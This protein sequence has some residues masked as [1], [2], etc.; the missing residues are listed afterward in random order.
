MSTP[1]KKEIEGKGAPA[2]SSVFQTGP[3]LIDPIERYAGQM[4]AGLAY[5]CRRCERSFEFKTPELGASSPWSRSPTA[6]PV[7]GVDPAAIQVCSSCFGDL[8]LLGTPKGREAVDFQLQSQLPD[9]VRDTVGDAEFCSFDT[10]GPHARHLSHIR[11]NVIGWSRQVL[12]HG[13]CTT[14][15]MYLYGGRGSWGSGSGNGKTYLGVSA[16]KYIGRRRSLL[17][18]TIKGIPQIYIPCAFVCVESL[19][20]NFLQRSKTEGQRQTDWITTDAGSWEVDFDAYIQHLAQIDYLFLDDVGYGGPNKMVG[21]VYAQIF[22]RRAADGTNCFI[23]SNYSPDHVDAQIGGRA[24]SRIFRGNDM[25]VVE[26]R[27]PD[28][29]R[30]QNDK[31]NADAGA[32]SL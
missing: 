5:V 19:V 32:R 24:A 14:P 27:A 22:E 6:K 15:G 16:Y 29:P 25:T 8:L 7:L 4:Q 31:R 17:L 3:N 26:V 10:S 11:Q 9:T 28:Y 2:V 18:G 12:K 21:R 30:L 13:V 23:T 1:E 20:K